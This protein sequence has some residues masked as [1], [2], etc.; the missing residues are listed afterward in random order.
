MSNILK[1]YDV[2]I[3]DCDGVLIDVNLMKCEAF[4]KAVEEYPKTTVERF[5]ENC[6]QTFGISRYIKFKDFFENFANEPF[7]EEKYQSFLTSYASI[8]KEI[9]NVADITPG[10]F[11][12]LEQLNRSDKLLFVASGSD[13]AE[14]NNAFRTRNLYKYFKKVYGSPRTKLECVD[15]ILRDFPTKNAV[16]IGDALSDLKTA[17]QHN[18]DFIYMSKYTVQSEQQDHIC[19]QEAILEIKTLEELI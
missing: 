3:F 15:E 11:T 12:L 19:K 1:K 9:Y 17:K 8:C 13:E 5:V 14:L 10:V 16:F 2:V 18:L 7:N 6:K 4:G